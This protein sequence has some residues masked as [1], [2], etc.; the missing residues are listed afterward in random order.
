MPKVAHFD[1]KQNGKK[2]DRAQVCTHG[3]IGWFMPFCV[4][5]WSIFGFYL[6]HFESTFYSDRGFFSKMCQKEY[7]LYPWE[8]L[9]WLLWKS[10][11]NTKGSITLCS[12]GSLNAGILALFAQVSCVSAASPWKVALTISKPL[13]E[14][15]AKVHGY[16]DNFTLRLFYFPTWC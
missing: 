7:F 16:L 2:L 15:F 3:Q 12:G 13:N 4:V 5:K 9:G 6:S 14:P 10:K 8:Y 1:G 11:I